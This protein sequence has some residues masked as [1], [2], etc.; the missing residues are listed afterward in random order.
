[1]NWG[2]MIL[3]AG[4]ASRM[5]KA[6]MLLPCKDKT[7]LEKIVDEVLIL[8][9]S[10]VTIVTGHYH[11]EISSV[12]KNEQVNLV[13]NN[14]YNMG[15]SSSI[16]MGLTAMQQQC[17]NMQLMFILVADQPFLNSALLQKMILLHTGTKKGLV[18][19][20]YQ[21]VAGTPL[22]LTAKYFNELNQLKG[23]KGARAIL[24]RH[25]S[26]LETIDFELGW[27]DIDT[28]ADYERFCELLNK[29][30]AD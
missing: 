19:A 22:L 12:I 10:V 1:M 8:D 9:P 18:A 16:Q 30:N 2:V 20:C 28:A 25:P 17:P 7:I 15:M 5:G 11:Q 4:E 23:D 6:K 27:L 13:R 29:G 21:D 14:N 3:A 26:D 24:H